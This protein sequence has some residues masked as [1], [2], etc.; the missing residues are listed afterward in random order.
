MSPRFSVFI[1]ALDGATWLPGAIESVLA[2]RSTDWELVIGDNASDDDLAVVVARYADPRIRYHRWGTRADIF[3]N[4]NRTMRLCK[5]PWVL[6]LCVDDRLDPGCLHEIT[7][8]IE[9]APSGPRRLGMVITAA[10]RIGP[11]GQ[12]VDIEYYGYR[13]R[14]VV[15]GGIYDAAGWLRVVTSPGSAPWDGGAFA[16]DVIEQMGLFYRDDVPDMSADL[17]LTLRIAA[18]ADVV[19]IDKPLLD[20]SGWAGSHTHGRRMRNRASEERLTPEASALLSALRA[21]DRQRTVTQ[22][23]RTAVRGAIAR[24]YLRRAAGHRYLPGG[25]GRRGAL[26]DVARAFRCS[27]S[28]VL[29]PAAFA[30]GLADI[31]APSAL[32]V[33][34]RR[35]VLAR[36]A[37]SAGQ[38]LMGT[39]ATDRE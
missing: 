26:L 29:A 27:P 5:A 4:F 11:D 10:R 12:P 22:A 15:K 20:V 33:T 13:G 24:S 8:Q 35:L 19:Y 30:Y 18:Y 1:P 25:R 9:A 6:L 7:R 14:A 2:Q 34:V 23:E 32:L 37:R 28:T 39:T 17:E 38:R 21:H 31:V 16:R 3:Q 36:R